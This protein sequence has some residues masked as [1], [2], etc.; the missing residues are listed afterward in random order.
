[1]NKAIKA[2][3]IEALKSGDYKK[4]NSALYYKN[5][6]T[7]EMEYC[8]LGVLC[9]LY[10][11]EHPET[12]S[13]RA[14]EDKGHFLRTFDVRVGGEVEELGC[15]SYPPKVVTEWADLHGIYVNSLAVKNDN[16]ATF[17]QIAEEIEEK[18]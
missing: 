10:Q 5:K 14:P 6:E 16:G 3:W 9:D 17:H 11:K 12:S 1:M 2:Q 7:E 8:C 13:W 15:N 18:H 4:G